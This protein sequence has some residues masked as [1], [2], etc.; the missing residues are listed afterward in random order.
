MGETKCETTDME[1]RR[2]MLE[3]RMA[4]LSCEDT[5]DLSDINKKASL[6]AG[7]V[8]VVAQQI[9]VQVKAV[10]DATT[11]LNA[12]IVEVEAVAGGAAL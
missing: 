9:V 12:M 1:V 3:S 7:N 11:K 4:G 5:A 2:A 10:V 8:L 6:N